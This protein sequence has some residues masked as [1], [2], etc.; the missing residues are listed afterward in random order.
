MKKLRIVFVS[1]LFAFISQIYAD[2]VDQL[3]AILRSFDTYTADFN[4]TN[5]SDKGTVIS[6]SSGRTM[7]KRPG[8]F[9]WESQAPTKQIII[10]DGKMLWIYDVDLAQVTKQTLSSK[11]PINP[12]M[13]L[14]GSA[15]ELTSQFNVSALADN[16]FV[17]TPKQSDY[18]FKR[19]TLKFSNNDLIEMVVVNNLA[20]TS[21]FEFSNVQLNTP[22]PDTLFTFQAP[23]GVDVISQ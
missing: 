7:I 14:S 4:Q 19:V 1:F 17:L 2:P 23:P 20:Q 6:Q 12:A 16:V 13:I 5:E 8:K 3:T 9:R 15:E 10:T 22:L 21:R 18:G 11:T